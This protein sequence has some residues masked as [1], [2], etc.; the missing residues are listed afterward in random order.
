MVNTYPAEVWKAVYNID[1]QDFLN[2]DTLTDAKKEV[3]RHKLIKIPK[4]QVQRE[5][6]STVKSRGRFEDFTEFLLE[7][8][9]EGRTNK[10]INSRDDLVELMNILLY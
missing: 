7:Q 8:C 1:I 6:Y 2:I 10:D 5:V 4:T 3:V 9:I